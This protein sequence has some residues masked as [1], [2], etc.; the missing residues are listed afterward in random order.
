MK[1]EV[2]N[3]NTVMNKDPKLGGLSFFEGKH[4]IPFSIKRMYC[5][6][7]AEEGKHRGF[8]AHKT[9]TQLVFCPYGCIEVQL[10]DGKNTETI[11]LDVPSKGLIIYPQIWRELTWRKNDSVLCVA[12]SDY[13]DPNENTQDYNEFLTYIGAEESQDC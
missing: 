2:I 3:L 1:Y 4:D 7:K 10:N 8:R 13:Y 12:V 5:I 9:S 11:V 6:Y